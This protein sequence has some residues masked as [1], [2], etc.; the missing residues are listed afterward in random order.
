M[1]E[2]KEQ[3]IKMDKKKRLDFLKSKT[4]FSSL[5]KEIFHQ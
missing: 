5:Y 1:E 3:K 2:V 4:F